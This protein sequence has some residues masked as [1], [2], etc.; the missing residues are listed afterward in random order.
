[1]MKKNF[2]LLSITL[3]LIIAILTNITRAQDN[4]KENR[5]NLL[6]S[7]AEGKHFWLVFMQN[8]LFRYNNNVDM[9]I[10]VGSRYGDTVTVIVPSLSI[11]EPAVTF[12]K[13]VPPYSVVTFP[14]NENFE[15][16]GEGVFNLGIEVYS[17]NHP[18]SVYGYNSK[19]QTSDGYLALPD[20][21]WGT[22]YISANYSV[23]SYPTD[24]IIQNVDPLSGNVRDIIRG[25]ESAVVAKEDSTYVTIY[26]TVPT[27]TITT[28]GKRILLMRGQV[29]QFQDS[30]RSRNGNDLTG[31]YVLSDKPVGF[32]SGHIRAGIGRTKPD[33]FNAEVSKDHIVE[34][35]PPTNELGRKYLVTPMQHRNSGG[36]LLRIIAGVQ[37]FGP[38]DVT[39]STNNGD[40]RNFSLNPLVRYYDFDLKDVAYIE[41]SAPIL[42]AQYSRSMWTDPDNVNAAVVDQL[43]PHPF[44]P[45]LVLATPNEQFVNAAVFQTLPNKRNYTDTKT[46]FDHHYVNIVGETNG[47][48]TLR[49]NGKLIKDYPQFSTGLVG[50][51]NFAYSYAYF[52]VPDNSV[53]ALQGDCLFGGIVYGVG[54]VD[55]YAWQIGA[56]L[57]KL[58]VIDRNKP[59]IKAKKDCAGWALIVTDSSKNDHGLRDIYLDSAYSINVE[60]KRDFLI[61]GDDEVAATV[62]TK[63]PTKSGRARVIAK[64]YF[65]PANYDTID[66]DLEIYKPEISFNGSVLSSLDSAEIKFF[67][68]F[69]ENKT[70]DL[71]SLDTIFLKFG[72]DS[73]NQGFSI[74]SIDGVKPFLIKRSLPKGSSMKVTIRF[75]GFE[76]KNYADILTV[77]ANCRPFYTDFGT[78][79]GKPLIR[80]DSLDFKSLRIGLDR[81]MKIH[82]KNPGAARLKIERIII[83]TNVFTSNFYLPIFLEKGKDTTLTICF[84]PK[85]VANY[86]GTIKFTGNA[87]SAAVGQ[88]KGSGIYPKLFISGYD[89]GKHQV[90]DTS[91]SKI[92][93]TNIGSD[94]ATLTG[95]FGLVPEGF[96]IDQTIFPLKLPQGDTVWVNVCYTAVKDGQNITDIT[97]LN[98]DNLTAINNLKGN[99]FILRAKLSG[100]D[101]LKRFINT[102]HDTV[103]YVTNTSNEKITIEKPYITSGDVSEF[104]ILPNQFPLVLNSGETATLPVRFTPKSRGQKK[105]I[106]QA[107]TS[108]RNYRIIDS[109]LAGY[110]LEAEQKDNISFDPTVSH[111]CDSRGGEVNLINTGNTPLTLS[112]LS[113]ESTPNIAK[114]I[115]QPLPNQI[116]DE[117]GKLT[118]KF[119][120]FL[121]GYVGN[122]IGKLTW[123]YVELPGQVFSKSF[124]WKSESQE[125]SIISS[126]P[127]KV[128]PLAI[129]NLK[130]NVSKVHWNNLPRQRV[131][132]DVKFDPLMALF[133]PEA[134][135]KIL[136]STKSDWLP[137]GQPKVNNNIFTIELRP[138]S[139]ISLPLDNAIFPEIPFVMFFSD[140]NKG[141]FN[142]TMR[143]DDSLCAP[144]T[145]TIQ[146]FKID[147]ICGLNNRLMEFTGVN[148]SLSPIEPNP[149][150]SSINVKFDLGFAGITTF[151]IFSTDGQ[152][153][154]TF[155]ESYLRDGHHEFNF[156]IGE[157]P[158]G[159]YICELKSGQYSESINLV[160]IK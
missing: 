155:I 63:D 16:I 34:M 148:Y 38:I 14:I 68:L 83:D 90:G 82:I 5:H 119:Y 115:N 72:L 58:D 1:M 157:I 50:P 105:C 32:F 136:D 92:Y 140:T 147:S 84:K 134:W 101:W 65:V 77:I 59:I 45:D 143:I 10:Q 138:R 67:D 130:V 129:L 9:R 13:Y 110:C 33:L 46:Q 20:N 100:Y 62:T 131:Y 139:G 11:F 54:L 7:N 86:T 23:D 27:K 30:S 87:D 78:A 108:S 76:R 80:V 2:T 160:I 17:M 79:I 120:V 141:V 70:Q 137:Y 18:I 66:L 127:E 124:S 135:T 96:Y 154:R 31:S 73:L 28:A 41:A 29:F 158:S 91:C 149:A 144:A 95:V 61:S 121:D 4:E 106:I 24:S 64:D 125:H 133:S 104:I 93:I 85:V 156:N 55:S 75:Q 107:Q 69:I 36:D 150:S 88:L 153:I 3:L 43:P 117:N 122:V 52:E 99:G 35:I 123:T 102:V 19:L 109:V 26:P 49:L 159:K 113:L 40:Y 25:S 6:G 151:K 74:F 145:Q 47:F 89:F 98:N 44:D 152:L 8:E 103:V 60:L 39:L 97:A 71:M 114:L 51:L 56:G 42:V 116:I 53:L 37:N 12:I 111:S 48:N 81:C 146:P 126:A 57:R 21:S 132:L 15:C 112:K 94:T 118:V 128:K 22:R 142:I